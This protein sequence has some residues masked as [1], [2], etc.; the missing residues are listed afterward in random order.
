MPLTM[1]FFIR[2]KQKLNELFTPFS[3]V[4]HRED[5]D[6]H[7]VLVS[8]DDDQYAVCRVHYERRTLSLV[9]PR[10]PKRG[11]VTA[12]LT[13]NGIGQI[14]EWSPRA[15]AVSAFD[16]LKGFQNSADNVVPLR[17]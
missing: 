9:S 12:P 10:E 6:S 1:E 15:C 17:A 5:G 7:L 8:K 13:E 14:L 2:M 16:R 4:M 11:R 3:V